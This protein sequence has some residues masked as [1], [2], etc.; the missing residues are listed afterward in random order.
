[1]V[2]NSHLRNAIIFSQIELSK[3]GIIH[4]NS[5][6]NQWLYEQNIKLNCPDYKMAAL[7]YDM[8]IYNVQWD[9]IKDIILL[10]QSKKRSIHLLTIFLKIYNLA[11]KEHQM[12]YHKIL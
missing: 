10:Y 7:I 8:G 11:I 6:L 3:D 2:K 1:M 12:L 4:D 9:K 5:K